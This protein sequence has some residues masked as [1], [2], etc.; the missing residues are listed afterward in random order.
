M[1]RVRPRGSAGPI[2]ALALILAACGGTSVP[3]STDGD[4]SPQRPCEGDRAASSP[5]PFLSAQ[6]RKDQ[7][8]PRLDQLVTAASRWGLG[9]VVGGIGYDYD[10]WLTIAAVGDDAAAGLGVWTKR[11]PDFRL[12]D[13]DSLKVRWRLQQSAAPHAW[14]ASGDRF[15]HLTLGKKSPLEV[16]SYD[17]ECGTRLWRVTVG[18]EPTIRYDDLATA[19]VG[20]ALAVL[21]KGRLSLLSAKS[22][23]AAWEVSAS[24]GEGDFL[25]LLDERTVVV[26]GWSAPRLADPSLDRKK[27][28]PAVA[29][30]SLDGRKRWS[31]TV[32]AGTGAHILGVRDGAVLLQ[33]VSPVV[34]H[35]SRLWSTARSPGPRSG[36][37][38]RT[39]PSSATCWSP[40]RSG[41]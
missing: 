2:A 5:G 18:S 20:D 11:D 36:C 27:A 25:G 12:L 3:S 26:G 41:C 1:I 24:A 33:R 14:D 13:P 34:R 39:P 21:V 31:W 30:Y 17:L 16:A 6:Q 19:P 28:M 22:G 37:R 35:G 9:Q 40:G 29:A 38:S 7:P 4:H 23:K 8:D 32:P 15:F 10:Q